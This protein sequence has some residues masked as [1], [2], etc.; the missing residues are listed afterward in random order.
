MSGERIRLSPVVA[1][2]M[3][4]NTLATILLATVFTLP[5]IAQALQFDPALV[6]RRPWTLLTYLFADPGF[7]SLGITLLVLAG[8]GPLVERD[9]GTRRFLLYYVVCAIGTAV[10]ALGLTSIG[11]IDPLAGAHGPALGVALAFWLAWPDARLMLDPLPVKIRVRTILLSVV[12]LEVVTGLVS[13]PG[14]AH[15]ADLGGL[16]AGYLVF[17]L[18]MIRSKRA[19]RFA[20]LTAPA[21]LRSLMARVE[22]R[23]NEASG[24][25]KAEGRAPSLRSAERR[26]TSRRA[27][28]PPSA[29]RIQ[30]DE[31][32]RVLDKISAF[33]MQ[34]LTA[35]ERQFLNRISE[36]KRKSSQ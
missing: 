1:A 36:R 13:E 2:L 19:Q 24:V 14:T 12:A 16:V 31:L 33:G 22:A 7:L 15:L 4:A 23:R 27:P 20:A 35:A 25:T 6:A 34:S 28:G 26:A 21:P 17:R 32:D 18:R 30:A 29:E 10:F 9:M 8:F 11:R 3:V 5:G